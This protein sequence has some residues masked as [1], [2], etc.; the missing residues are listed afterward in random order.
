MAESMNE[1]KQNSTKWG[2]TLVQL[3]C[4]P[5]TDHPNELMVTLRNNAGHTVDLS[6]LLPKGYRFIFG[7]HF[8][9]QGM[10]LE[11]NGN[12]VEIPRDVYKRNKKGALLSLLHE[13]GHIHAGKHVDSVSII[14]E[15]I[16]DTAKSMGKMS[17][18]M[19]KKG[20]E[21]TGEVV[22]RDPT[23]GNI[24]DRINIRNWSFIP[25]WLYESYGKRVAEIERAPWAWALMQARK[26]QDADFD[27]LSEF[28]SFSDMQKY[29]STSL[30]TYDVALL[31]QFGEKKNRLPYTKR[32]LK[33]LK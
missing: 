27:V 6:F 29:I 1:K 3:E 9:H 12:V 31:T 28:E 22:L 11:E 30:E 15:M 18:A 13:I 26:L 25:K 23:T 4:V 17:H 16:M 2:D 32:H 21:E 24:L 20:Y 5:K 10:S 7:N 14:E 8:S 19:I 33:N